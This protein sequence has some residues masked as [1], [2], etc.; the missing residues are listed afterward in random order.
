MYLDELA[1]VE[2][3]LVTVTEGLHVCLC[4]SLAVPTFCA[5]LTAVIY[6]KQTK[7]TPQR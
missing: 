7:D 5:L 1:K 6:L 4:P 2:L 3:L